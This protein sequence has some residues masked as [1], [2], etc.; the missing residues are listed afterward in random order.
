[1]TKARKA[2]LSL[3]T[4]VARRLR[5][6]GFLGKTVTLKVKYHDFAQITRSV[7]LQESTDDGREIFRNCCELLG[8]TEVGKR[9][10]RLLGIS[11]SQLDIA[12]EEKQLMLFEERSE[13]PKRKRLNRALDTISDKFGEEAIVPGTLLE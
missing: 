2:L 5:G 11:L 8:K 1:M 3:A 13:T 9:P 12:E 7:T 10:V 6:H 4:R